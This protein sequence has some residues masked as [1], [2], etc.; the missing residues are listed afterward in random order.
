MALSANL[1]F[2]NNQIGLY[3]RTYDVVECKCHFNRHHN[4]NLPDAN[5]VC[6]KMELTVVAPGKEDLNLYEWYIDGTKQSGI[7]TF[8]LTSTSKNGSQ[9]TKVIWFEDATCFS[10]AENYDIGKQHR[11]QLTLEIV[12][13]KITVEN[14]DFEHRID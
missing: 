10:I 4:F 1:K 13:A 14:V 11:R 9:A 8:D 6:D 5:A 2:G 3:S 12:A 7:L